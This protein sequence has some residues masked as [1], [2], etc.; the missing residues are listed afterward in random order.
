V[1]SDPRH[2]AIITSPV[3]GHL[4]P[5]QVLGAELAAAGARVTV[6]HVAGT[7]RFGTE[8]AVAFAALPERAGQ[9]SLDTYLAT[10]GSPRG[11]IGLSRMIRATAGMAD[12]LL[13]GAPEVIARIG[14]DTIIADAVEPAGP[15]IAQAMGLRHVGVVTGLPMFAEADVPPPF[16]GWPYRPDEAGRRRNR[17][18]YAVSQALLRPIERVLQARREAWRLGP[19]R[20]AVVHVAQCPAALD[21]PR[22]RLP[23]RF[24]YG[25]PWRHDPPA[26]P[27]L[28]ALDEA[29]DGRPLI[30]CSLGTLQ[31]ARLK[32]LATMAQACADIGAR[33]VIAHCGG[34]RPDQ[35][36]ELPGDPLV[37]AFWPQTAVMRRCVAAVLH[38]G[39]N[40]TID[41]LAAGLPMVLLPI[42][43]EQPGTAAR[44]ARIGAGRVLSPR[45]LSVPALAEAL[46]AIL[47]DPG[48]RAA[49]QRLARDMAAGGGARSAARLIRAALDGDYDART[50]PVEP[51]ARQP[52]ILD[53]AR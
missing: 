40:S 24:H 48:Y 37:R 50:E 21:Y 44:V 10:L 49:S 53:A 26:G 33:A 46:S 9:M 6:V 15:L 32:L 34:L 45:W 17:G 41:A 8:P 35:E 31:G 39:F 12:A 5:V 25:S 29:G 22:T 14:A 47:S 30:F 52:L 13:A 16:L 42:A 1:T 4:N 28:H 20:D 36:G 7:E 2:Y 51:T 19:A 23:D 38:G 3:P 27:D 18:G 43:F 11:P